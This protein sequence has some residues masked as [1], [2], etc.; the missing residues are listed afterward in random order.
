MKELVSARP[1]VRTECREGTLYSLIDDIQSKYES[2]LKTYENLRSHAPYI[3]YMTMFQRRID[4]AT[5]CRDYMV[6]Y[7]NQRAI[8][9]G[10]MEFDADRE[11]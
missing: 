2:V 1:A 6:S 7:L 5:A 4:S 11:N 9:I 10:V 3:D 8:Q